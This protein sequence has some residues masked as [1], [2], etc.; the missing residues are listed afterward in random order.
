MAAQAERLKISITEENR[1]IKALQ[2]AAYSYGGF[3]KVIRGGYNGGV[4]PG[5]NGNNANYF[6][7]NAD[8][9]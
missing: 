5:S 7:G 3:S 9:K 2:E 8:C 4:Y 1:A 6:Q